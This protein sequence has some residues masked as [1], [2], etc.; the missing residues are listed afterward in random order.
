MTVD[1]DQLD[2]KACKPE[3]TIMK[4]SV[5]WMIHNI[6]CEFLAFLSTF[7]WTENFSAGQNVL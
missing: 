5:Q 4:F 7:V 1:S 2:W 3:N 6:F